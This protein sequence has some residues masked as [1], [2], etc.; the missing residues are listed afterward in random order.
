M[1]PISGK[2]PNLTTLDFVNKASTTRDRT[3]LQPSQGHGGLDVK[4]FHADVPD[5]ANRSGGKVGGW[6]RVIGFGVANF[7]TL[8][9]VGMVGKICANSSVMGSQKS[10]FFKDW[11]QTY[12]NSTRINQ[13]DSKFTKF[14][15]G[16]G[17]FYSNIMPGAWLG[18][19]VVL[20]QNIHHNRAVNQEFGNTV[21]REFGANLNYN[22]VKDLNAQTAF[23][24]KR[25]M[26]GQLN[27]EMQSASGQGR[28][29]DYRDTALRKAVY[30]GS[31]SLRA[32][33][34]NHAQD[35][36]YSPEN[37]HFLSWS[38]ATLD[39]LDPASP[40]HDRKYQL[41]KKELLT[42]KNDFVRSG[43][44]YELNL[45][46]HGR[47]PIYNGLNQVL[48]DYEQRLN[49]AKTAV[50]MNP[51]DQT[52][53]DNLARIENEKL[54]PQESQQALPALKQAD[55]EIYQMNV[56]DA[57]KRFKDGVASK[58][59]QLGVM[60]DKLEQK[61]VD[62]N[63]T[64]RSLQDDERKLQQDLAKAQKE[65]KLAQMNLDEKPNDK[66]L[67]RELGIAKD[68]VTEIQDELN[69]VQKLIVAADR[70][71]IRAQAELKGHYRN[72]VHND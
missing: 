1:N 19:P 14:L 39:K 29:G 47:G 57:F 10:G 56:N 55:H 64:Y 54:N 22:S 62:S 33:F 71:H 12:L 5:I 49:Q 37:S 8:G 51:N 58:A 69:E 43:S 30:S 17:K 9:A 36:E 24:T 70:E 6:A 66:W 67:K 53:K 31:P 32:A 2:V 27:A 11:G 42:A 18:Q 44:Q 65:Q 40:N 34:A 7:L 13:G 52:A 41:S 21:Q 15:K 45:S 23:E 72:M 35:V 61:V 25:L 28:D 3:Q 50:R 20:G 26:Y 68:N 4:A 16:A 46:Y 59:Q 60:P 38:S 48:G 63:V